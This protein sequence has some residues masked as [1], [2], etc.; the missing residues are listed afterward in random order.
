MSYQVSIVSKSGNPLYVDR[1]KFV[2]ASRSIQIDV[3]I[4][5]KP[6]QELYAGFTT[7]GTLSNVFWKNGEV[8]ST[9]PDESLVLLLINLSEKLGGELE[10][11]EGEKYIL[12]DGKILCTPSRECPERRRFFTQKI[13]FFIGYI[14]VFLLLLGIAFGIRLIM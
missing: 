13:K 1:S 12:K 9:N 3:L 8:W 2:N 5:E 10:G 7:E 6:D 14:A 11:D 4:N